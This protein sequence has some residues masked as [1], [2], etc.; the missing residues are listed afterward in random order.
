MLAILTKFI[1]NVESKHYINQRIHT[2]DRKGGLYLLGTLPSLFP[3]PGS[4]HYS[5]NSG[6]DLRLIG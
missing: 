5:G 4:V 6:L 2:I 1:S 3:V